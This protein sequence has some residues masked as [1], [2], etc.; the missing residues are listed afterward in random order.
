MPTF[1]PGSLKKLGWDKDLTE[2]DMA[3]ITRS[4]PQPDSCRRGR[5]TSWRHPRVALTTLRSTA[6]NGK[7]VRLTAFGLPDP[8]SSRHRE[9]IYK[10]AST[11]FRNIDA[12]LRPAI[13]DAQYCF[14]VIRRAVETGIANNPAHPAPRGRLVRIGGGGGEET[15]TNHGVWLA[16]LQQDMFSNSAK[17]M[18]RSAA[19][20]LRRFW[21]HVC[22]EPFQ[23]QDEG[24]RHRALSARASLMS[25]PF[26]AAFAGRDLSGELY[27]PKGT[28]PIVLLSLCESANTITTY[29]A[30]GDRHAGPKV[31]PCK[32]AA[33]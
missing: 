23:G 1:T 7:V 13:P 22:R 4:T 29:G 12:A 33:A 18:H 20:G 17:P 24:A 8:D 30:P 19:Q 11:W 25:R 28:E 26:A 15:R 3:T 31:T 6:T 32:F 9:P 14:S 21:V 27:Y 2:A 10:R 5:S 16:E